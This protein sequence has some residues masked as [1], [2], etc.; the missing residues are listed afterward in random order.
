MEAKLNIYNDCTSEEPS[1]TY[2]C[3][4]LTYGA[5]Q[6]IDNYSNQ[7]NS[8]EKKK[9]AE[10]KKENPDSN[11][12]VEISEEQFKLNLDI[13][14]A[15]FPDFQDE[16]FN[17]IDVYEYQNFMIEVGKEKQRIFDRASKN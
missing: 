13:L 9:N 17:G 15:I 1:K 6:K 4:R 16:D 10:L 7:V 11:L 12:I 5:G 2:V 3:R 14:R 8:L